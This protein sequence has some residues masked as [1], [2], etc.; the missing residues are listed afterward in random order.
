MLNY[1][2]V[3]FPTSPEETPKLGVKKHRKN[4]STHCDIQV[5]LWIGMFTH[6]QEY[7]P[8]PIPSKASK[9]LIQD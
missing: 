1:R 9:C 4:G 7:S 2:R 3:I 5:S 8:I 6:V